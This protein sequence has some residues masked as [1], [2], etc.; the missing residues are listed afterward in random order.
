MTGPHQWSTIPLDNQTADARANWQ[1]GQPASSLNNSARGMMAT[2]AL[3]RDDNLGVAL[4]AALGTNNVYGVLTGQGL[5]DPAST[6]GGGTARITKPFSLRLRFDTALSG[7]AANPPKLAIDNA[8]PAALVKA[9]G[10]ALVDADLGTTRPYEILGYGFTAG[11]LT[12]IRIVS[13]LPSD[14]A[15]IIPPGILIGTLIDWPSIVTPDTFLEPVG[16]LLSRADYP[17]L[18]SFAQASGMLVSEAA[19]AIDPGK[20]ST[21]DGSTT[22]RTMDVRG[23]FIRT[24]DSGRGID[25]G[26]VLGSLQAD[27][28]KNHTHPL[29]QGG[30]VISG[31]SGVMSANVATGPYLQIDAIAAVGGAETRPRNTAYRKLL[32]YK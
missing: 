8:A 1:E 21:G 17:A 31:Y 6:A 3:A 15:V 24:L 29:S 9:D 2:A 18:W 4:V 22:F 13:L 11:V 19:W 23:D 7:V 12:T 30:V 26:R 5:I 27:A 14:Y 20:F 10:S 16:A 28:F 32:K 25:A